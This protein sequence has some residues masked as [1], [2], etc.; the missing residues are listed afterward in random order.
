[1]QSL[2]QVTESERKRAE[3]ILT[4][5]R[6]ELKIRIEDFA[7]L[8][9]ARETNDPFRILVVTILTQNC[10]DVAALRAYRRLD[11]QVGVTVQHLRKANLREIRKAIRVAGLYKQKSRGLKELSQA[12]VERYRGRFEDALKGPVDE[13][14]V[15]LQQLPRVGPKT[16]D[17]ILGVLG[18]PTISVDTHVNRVSKR[19]GLAPMRAGYDKVRA[20]LMQRFQVEDYNKIPLYLMAHGR[21][22]CRARRPLCP[23]CPVR[24][25]CPYPKKTYA[26]RIGI[27]NSA[28]K[29]SERCD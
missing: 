1:M 13:V 17:V 23:S 2:T 25:L 14:R 9:I 21:R 15:S 24:S 22:T 18:H 16:A 12:L 20:S 28:K 26:N 7:T 29:S 4:I 27:R 10:T 11:E 8:T 19:L 6:R 3:Q 5:L